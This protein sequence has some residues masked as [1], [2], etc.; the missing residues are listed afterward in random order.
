MKQ[1]K[2]MS[3][4]DKAFTWAD[5][6]QRELFLGTQIVGTIMTGILCYKAGTKAE[7]ILEK[8]KEKM[9]TIDIEDKEARKN[10]TIDT[11]KDMAPIIVPPLVTGVMTIGCAIGGYKAS[12]KQIAALS[13]AYALSEKALNEY[14]AKATELLGKKKAQDVKD[15]VCAD[16]VRHDPPS[17]KEI[18]I[19]GSGETLCYDDYSGRYFKSDPETI[20]KVVND[21]NEQL[22][23]DYYV[24]L[25]EFYAGLNLANVKLGDDLGFCIDDG[26]LNLSFSATLTENNTPC[27]VLNY[28][29]SPKYGS[30]TH[31]GRFY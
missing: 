30:S 27:L 4:I 18:Y 15:A 25:N 22:R 5:E 13:A 20:R 2:L 28:D 10:E 24:S 26:Y 23:D 9:E 31:P 17:G 16:H 29:V 21:I 6:H 12:T 7:D 1:G 14:T 11:V 3:A 8:H 19:T